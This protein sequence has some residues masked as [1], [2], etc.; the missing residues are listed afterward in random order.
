VDVVRA[1]SRK[2]IPK[3]TFLR[4]LPLVAIPGLFLALALTTNP[5]PTLA[6][7]DEGGYLSL[8]RIIAGGHSPLGSAV[9]PGYGAFL[10]PLYLIFDSPIWIWRGVL[11]LNFLCSVGTLLILDQLVTTWAPQIRF[12]QRIFV[13]LCL[14][15]LPIFSTMM[16][17]AFPSLLTTLL[18]VIAVFSIAKL[19][20]NNSKNLLTL[21]ISS[22]LLLSIHPSNVAP[23][24]GSLAILLLYEDK[25]KH[26]LI[27]LTVLF[28]IPVLFLLVLR[29]V[30]FSRI[31]RGSAD[32]TS[33]YSAIGV[34]KNVLLSIGNFEFVKNFAIELISLSFVFSVATFGLSGVIISSIAQARNKH[35]EDIKSDGA[36]W[37]RLWL[38]GSV[39][40]SLVVTARSFGFT[41]DSAYFAQRLEAFLFL[42]YADPLLIPL[43]AIGLLDLGSLKSLARTKKIY[44]SQLLISV[45]GGALLYQI[46]L[47]AG[48]DSLI[49]EAADFHKFMSLSFWPLM[50]T[51][52]VR[53]LLW[54]ILGIIPLVL[55]FISRFRLHL[56][57]VFFC[58]LVTIPAQQEFYHRLFDEFGQT[59]A[60]GRV[61]ESNYV[62]GLCVGWD[63]T[64]SEIPLGLTQSDIGTSF[65]NLAFQLGNYS[66]R[67]MD[68]AIWRKECNGPLITY[69]PPHND[70]IVLAHDT[71]FRLFLVDRTF[72]KLGSLPIDQFD[73]QLASDPNDS[74]MR[75]NCFGFN[76]SQLAVRSETGQMNG[77]LLVSSD[78]A[79]IFF[80]SPGEILHSGAYILELVGEF[81]LQPDSEI[82]ISWDS[83]ASSKT[84]ALSSN[85][86]QQLIRVPF[87]LD[88]WVSDLTFTLVQNEASKIKFLGLRVVSQ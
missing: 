28:A 75:S 46:V 18:V 33:G 39:L 80:Q 22:G 48:W 57:F 10:S 1:F 12:Q 65:G 35:G 85:V 29:P 54:L 58:G 38:L 50:I 60:L 64:T 2:T 32:F 26:R 51:K 42:R 6:S 56:L 16:N 62:G 19:P 81:G 53:P 34:T 82:R 87:Q 71:R 77:N 14:S 27:N 67:G 20:K 30:L 84:I 52:E 23:F 69:L 41:T 68:R 74:C 5:G 45:V 70:D 83:G 44:L 76:A 17:Y 15:C 43:I 66:F 59:S 72:R 47:K 40:L 11:F 86:R 3:H 55:L 9:F 88:S 31:D 36:F 24:L 25:I 61:I 49:P 8:A 78:H 73:L 79:G 13:G 63:I 4:L 21:A 7:S 37:S